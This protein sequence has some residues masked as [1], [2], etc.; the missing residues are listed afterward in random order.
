MR[1]ACV[2]LLCGTLLAGLP[3]RDQPEAPSYVGARVCASCHTGKGMGHQYSLWLL[4]GHSRAWA[5]LA[6]PKGYEA[7]RKRGITTEAQ[8]HPDCLKCHATYH[9]EG[10]E[11]RL[12]SFSP[13]EGVGCEACHGPGSSYIREAVM[14]DKRAATAAGLKPVSRDTCL[15]CHPRGRAGGLP[16]DE[17]IKK[18]AHPTRPSSAAQE[19]R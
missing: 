19:S 9:G 18:I 16:L 1:L 7:A 3:A 13:D 2:L 6:T 8:E 17:A 11:G 4:S 5:V 10:T 12:A 14:R 15:R